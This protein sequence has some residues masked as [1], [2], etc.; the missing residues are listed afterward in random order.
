[1]YA[2]HLVLPWLAIA[3]TLSTTRCAWQA[4]LDPTQINAVIGAQFARLVDGRTPLE[5]GAAPTAEAT[6]PGPLLEVIST[7]LVAALE[8]MQR[9]LEPG[10]PLSVARHTCDVLEDDPQWPV[11]VSV[12]QLLDLYDEHHRQLPRRNQFSPG[13]DLISAAAAIARTPAVPLPSESRQNS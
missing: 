13:W 1:M 6:P 5:L 2:D 8:A 9:G 11:F 7:N 12:R 10:V 4:G 3:H